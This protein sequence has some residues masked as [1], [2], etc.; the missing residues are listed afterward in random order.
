MRFEEE[1]DNWDINALNEFER[2]DIDLHLSRPV[3]ARAGFEFARLSTEEKLNLHYR[4]GV[5]IKLDHKD[6]ASLIYVPKCLVELAESDS[7]LT[8]KDVSLFDLDDVN[9]LMSRKDWAPDRYNFYSVDEK[10][11]FYLVHYGN[12]GQHSQKDYLR[13]ERKLKNLLHDPEYRK[14]AVLYSQILLKGCRRWNDYKIETKHNYT[15][16]SDRLHLL[17]N[18]LIQ[19]YAEEM[20]IDL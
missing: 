8:C 9:A 12:I 14:N 2:Q 19:R 4:Y 1:L 17:T 5:G 7:G 15:S 18:S 3:S 10:N 11:I 16:I 20:Q 6:V 13:S